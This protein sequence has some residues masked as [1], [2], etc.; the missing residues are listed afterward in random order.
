MVFVSTVCV[1]MLVVPVVLVTLLHLKVFLFLSGK[2]LSASQFA[3]V[4]QRAC[5]MSSAI[6]HILLFMSLKSV[7]IVDLECPSYIDTL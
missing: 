5:R 7:F 1:Q 6:G 3:G 4:R 2:A